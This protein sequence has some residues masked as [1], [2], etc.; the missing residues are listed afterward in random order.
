MEEEKGR[1]VRENELTISLNEKTTI[2]EKCKQNQ[3]EAEKRILQCEKQLMEKDCEIKKYQE[4]ISTHNYNK[5]KLEQLM[6]LQSQK[7]EEA[8]KANANL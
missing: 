6:H 1:I 5:Q 8:E 4:E 3:V 7:L 2:I